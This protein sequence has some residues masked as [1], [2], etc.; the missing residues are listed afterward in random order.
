MRQTLID[1]ECA[2]FHRLPCCWQVL[3]YL[4]LYTTQCLK[5]LEKCPSA[6]E[7]LKSLTAM[8]VGHPSL[9]LFDGACAV[10]M[11]F[12]C[13]RV[14]ARAQHE[15]FRIPGDV[16]FAL[17]SFFPAPA[18]AQVCYRDLTPRAARVRVT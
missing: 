16:G 7:G 15:S 3:I 12:D 4:T 17:G 9:S 5:K 8:A 11:A 6:V 14:C 18:T 1:A 2:K 13:V 10:S